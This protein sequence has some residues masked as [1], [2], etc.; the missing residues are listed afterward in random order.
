MRPKKNENSVIVNDRLLWI[1]Y[2]YVALDETSN[3]QNSTKSFIKLQQIY[4]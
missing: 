1:A 3:Y 2:I 4:T